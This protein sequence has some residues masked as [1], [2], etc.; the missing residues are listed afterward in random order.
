MRRFRAAGT[1]EASWRLA[2]GLAV[3]TAALSM[4]VATM[5]GPAAMA[6]PPA[7]KLAISPTTAAPGQTVIVTGTDL[8]PRSIYQVQVCGQNAVHGSADCAAAAT[9][10]TQVDPQGTLSVPVAVVLPPTQCPCVV[11]AFPVTVGPQLTTPISIEGASTSNA[12]TT[13]PQVPTSHLVVVHAGFTGSTPLKQWFGFQATRTLAVS[14]LNRGSARASDM[15]LF[16]SL[17]NTPVVSTRLSALGAGQVRTYDVPVTFP[18]LTVGNQTLKGHV[19]TEDGQIVEFKTSTSVWPIGLVVVALILVQMI[20]LAWRNIARRRYERN[21]PKPT[22]P[23]DP[24]TMETEVV[25]PLSET[26]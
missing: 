3:L 16:A 20:L 18:A 14:L 2:V 19:V 12:P 11:A 26:V 7:P 9:S 17:G 6:A 23:E 4:G 13:T 15:R 10:T 22:E 24:P 5:P 1:I 25:P 21:N 8:T